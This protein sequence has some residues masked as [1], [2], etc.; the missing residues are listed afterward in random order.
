[1]CNFEC[2]RC[3]EN[4]IEYL[5]SHL[6]CWECGYGEITDDRQEQHLKLRIAIKNI[7]GWLALKVDESRRISNQVEKQKQRNE[8]RIAQDFYRL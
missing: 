4:K 8:H 1:M 5:S 7:M 3:G 2:P 6:F